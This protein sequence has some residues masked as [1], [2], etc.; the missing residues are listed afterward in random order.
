MLVLTFHSVE[1][2]FLVSHRRA[3]YP[4]IEMSFLLLANVKAG[5]SICSVGYVRRTVSSLVVKK[6]MHQNITQLP[7]D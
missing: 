7:L 3:S 1:V 4:I 5:G 6:E 2:R